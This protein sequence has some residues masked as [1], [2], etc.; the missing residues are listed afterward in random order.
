MLVA[1]L[2]LDKHID[3]YMVSDETRI[4][5]ALNI[6]DDMARKLGMISMVLFYIMSVWLLKM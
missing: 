6:I 2:L 5:D 1:K 4:V 3:S